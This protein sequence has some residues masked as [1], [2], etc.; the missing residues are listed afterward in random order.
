MMAIFLQD[1]DVIEWFDLNPSSDSLFETLP[2]KDF[3]DDLL[4]W[5]YILSIWIFLKYQNLFYQD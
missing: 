2:I 3:L 4:I 5:L 1:F